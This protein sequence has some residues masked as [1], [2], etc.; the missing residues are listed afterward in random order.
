MNGVNGRDVYGVK[1]N[2]NV[3]D[4]K[5]VYFLSRDVVFIENYLC[6]KTTK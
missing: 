3:C 4:G 1:V 6:L 5:V 2:M